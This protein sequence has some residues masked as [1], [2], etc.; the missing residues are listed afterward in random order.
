[1]RNSFILTSIISLLFTAALGYFFSPQWLWLLLL[2]IPYIG[3]GIQD[4]TQT[5]H[6][7]RRIFPVFGRG[8]YLMEWLRPKMYQY[9]IESDT[10]GK[11]ISRIQRS[12]VYQRAKKVVD[13][14]PFG[15]QLD[16]YAEGYEWMNHSIAALDSHKLDHDLRVVVGGSE[17]KQPYSASI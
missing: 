9:F 17:C 14:T 10:D 11:P 13:T 2:V 3:L 4:L 12:V 16:V 6:A 15:T 8:R 5:K 7:I 1:M